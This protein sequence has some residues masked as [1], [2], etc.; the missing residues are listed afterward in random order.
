MGGGRTA[1]NVN[2]VVTPD[3]LIHWP[4][5]PAPALIGR[6]MSNGRR[7]LK[8]VLWAG[9]TESGTLRDNRGSFF[10]SLLNSKFGSYLLGYIQVG[11]EQLPISFETFR[12]RLLA[13]YPSKEERRVLYGLCAS[14]AIGSAPQTQPDDRKKRGRTDYEAEVARYSGAE[15]KMETLLCCHC[16]P[17]VFAEQKRGGRD[18][19]GSS[20]AGKPCEILLL[21]TPP[22]IKGEEVAEYRVAKVAKVAKVKG[23]GTVGRIDVLEAKVFGVD[24]PPHSSECV[25]ARLERLE[26]STFGSAQTQSGGVMTRLALIE[27]LYA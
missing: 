20:L 15:H 14:A 5:M 6:H 2:S 1:V 24:A 12:G 4:D 21:P 16:V 8:A 7:V 10:L 19:D 17:G 23:D 3:M 13:I 26:T 11:E 25:M 18:S 22:T 27:G 9:Q